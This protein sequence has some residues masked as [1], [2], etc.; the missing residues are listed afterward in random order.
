M[1]VDLFGTTAEIAG[2]GNSAA[3]RP[4]L[5]IRLMVRLL[6]LKHAY[7]SSDDP[8]VERWAQDVLFQFFSGQE[9]FEHRLP[10]DSSLISRFR[11]F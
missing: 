2:A 6:H 10:C 9:Y 3:G 5:P 4:R 8:L 7:S 11:C 1:V